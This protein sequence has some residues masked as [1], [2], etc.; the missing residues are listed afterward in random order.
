MERGG[1]KKYYRDDEFL[2]NV[3]DRIRQ[4]RLERGLTQMELAFKCNET[5]YSQINRIELGKVNFSLS[6][7]KLIADILEVNPEDLIN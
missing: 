3:G 2:K 6:F 4:L 5:D 7:L 1:R